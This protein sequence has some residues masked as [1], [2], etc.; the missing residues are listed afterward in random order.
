MM[1]V[2]V[3]MANLVTAW[4]RF[5]NGGRQ[6]GQAGEGEKAGERESFDLHL[7]SLFEDCARLMMLPTTAP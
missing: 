4:C 6:E 7:G 5:G 2:P 3:P 1:V